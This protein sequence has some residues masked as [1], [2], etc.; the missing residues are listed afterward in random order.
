MP[1]KTW[2]HVRTH[3]HI[4][5]PS[6]QLHI[7]ILT[8]FVSSAFITPPTPQHEEA[9]CHSY[10]NN[11]FFHYQVPI[12]SIFLAIL[13]SLKVLEKSA[14]QKSDIPFVC[15]ARTLCT[16]VVVNLRRATVSAA[17]RCSPNLLGLTFFVEPLLEASRHAVWS[18][19]AQ[20]EYGD[21]TT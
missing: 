14:M 9:S 20:T 13:I 3:I 4:Y 1:L 12:V 21:V 16:R 6:P 11:F 15:T 19:C 5:M 18:A 10:S 7:F 2:K 17:E 8:H